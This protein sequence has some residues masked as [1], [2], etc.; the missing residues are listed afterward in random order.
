M[1]NINIVDTIKSEFAVSPED[2]D[3]IYSLISHNLSNNHSVCL[4][5]ENVDIITTAFLNN[6]IGKLYKE[7]DKEKL[8][9][10][11]TMKNKSDSDLA[12]LKKVI[13]RAK[14]TFTDEEIKII[15]EEIGDD[16]SN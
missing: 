16:Q 1:K 11:I 8:N 6:A 14:I 2:G 7:F 13:D 15:G 3:I 10:F 12:L 5:F 9:K 4:N